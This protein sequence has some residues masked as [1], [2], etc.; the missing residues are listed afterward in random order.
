MP[1]GTQKLVLGAI[2]LG[3]GSVLI[4]ASG[5]LGS[6]VPGIAA[7]VAAVA[8]T[9]GTLLIGLSEEGVGV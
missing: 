6:P 8:M 4:F 7:A 3:V 1:T 9:A 2:A 5:L